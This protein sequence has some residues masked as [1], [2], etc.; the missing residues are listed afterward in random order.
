MK[1]LLFTFSGIIALRVASSVQTISTANAE[2]A[3]LN[4]DSV[5]MTVPGDTYLPVDILYAYPN[6]VINTT[7]ILFNDV[8]DTEA[9]VCII[10]L[11]G[12]TE[13]V[14]RHQPGVTFI[15]VDMGQLREG[16]Y[17]VR[18]F[19]TNRVSFLKVVKAK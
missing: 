2:G 16:L 12:R 4:G 11:N 17:S 10:N 15:D 14:Q 6:P 13:R 18:V 7:R 19:A 9:V 5:Q 8:T 3:Y 1:T